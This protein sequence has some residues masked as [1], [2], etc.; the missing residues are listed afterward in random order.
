MEKLPPYMGPARAVQ[1]DELPRNSNGTFDRKAAR[2][3]LEQMISP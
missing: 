3:F 2:A 1:R